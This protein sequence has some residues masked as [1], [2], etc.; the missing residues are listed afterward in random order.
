MIPNPLRASI[1]YLTSHFAHRHE[2]HHPKAPEIG[3]YE[4]LSRIGEGGMGE[5]WVARHRR[6][7]R[8]VA[9]K[10]IRPDLLAGDSASHETAISRFE[11]EATA[12]AALR[13]PHT[14]A[15]HDFGVTDDGTFYYVM[16]LLEGLSLDALVRRFG[17]ITPPRT[18]GLLRQV[19][20]S[21]DEAHASGLIHRD[22]KPAN[23]FAC[24][25]GLD[26][27]FVKVLDFGL[28]KQAVSPDR[29]LVSAVTADGVA[30]GTP[31]Y[32]A[33]EVAMGLPGVDGHADMYALGC[34]AYWMLTG[35]EVFA[36]PTP[37]ATLLAHV[38]A[39]PVPPSRRTTVAIPAPLESAIMACLAKDPADRPTAA[40]L[41]HRLGAC[42][43]CGSWTADSA[44]LWWHH[45]HVTDGLTAFAS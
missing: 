6:L 29:T 33:P 32:M 43:S 20:H 38:D 5:V 14:V 27:D 17:P 24:R 2:T 39:K 37:T 41:D 19:C 16:E 7:G 1:A 36:E 4:L 22:I 15:V 45:H 42:E 34:V 10:M 35:Q 26:F 9:I 28:V 11:R 40:E 3:G 13:S 23:I 18:V 44:R 8:P 30:A 12:T 21:L 31:A 25:L